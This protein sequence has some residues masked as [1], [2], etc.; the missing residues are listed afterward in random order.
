VGEV[1][2][3]RGATRDVFENEDGSFTTSTEI[4][5]GTAVQYFG[6]LPSEFKDARATSTD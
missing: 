3:K 1:V 2:D 4:A 5:A 6:I